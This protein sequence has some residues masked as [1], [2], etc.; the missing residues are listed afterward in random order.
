MAVTG[1]ILFGFV[2]VHM[3]GNLQVYMGPEKINSYA[4][5]LRSLG[6][7]LW[8]AR[9][10]LLLSVLLHIGAAISL[11]RL[12]AAARPVGYKMRGNV[13]SSYAARTMKFSGI[14][15]LAFIVYHLMHFTFGN[16]HPNFVH[17]DVYHNF[18]VGFR[19]VPV[20]IAYVVANLLL[21][22]HLYHGFYSMFQSLGLTHP[23]YTPK[24]KAGAL[25]FAFV[26]TAG[27]VS[28]PISVL[29]GVIK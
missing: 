20:T 26:I 3:I 24:I 8:I 7:L 16:V 12:S 29:A 6:S 19:Q 11:V 9:G 23:A 1:V 21:G 13:N 15:L 28:M 2:L 14:L 22:T 17:L 18:V 25:L 5:F 10:I 27:N 4:R